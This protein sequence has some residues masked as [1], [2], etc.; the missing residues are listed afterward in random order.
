VVTNLKVVDFNE[1][2]MGIVDPIII[3]DLSAD[4]GEDKLNINKLLMTVYDN[5]D[6]LSSL[7]SCMC[8]HLHHGY[9]LNVICPLCKS[10]VVRPSEADIELKI[11]IRVPDGITGFI[12]PLVWV[13][14]TKLLSPSGYNLMEWLTNPRSRPA[15]KMSVDTS[16]IINTLEGM[17]WPR[18]INEFINNFDRLMEVIPTLKL[19]RKWGMYVEHFIRNRAVLFPRMLP[20][21]TK[22]LL[23]L[24]NTHLGSYADLSMSAAIDAVRSIITI[25]EYDLDPSLPAPPVVVSKTVS[26][27]KNLS[28][29]YMDT[30]KSYFF[31]K[32]GWLRGQVFSSRTHFCA[33]GVITS[34]TAEHNYEE[35]HIP[36]AQG[37][38]L[39]KYHIIP[40]LIA[41][42]Y[43]YKS[44]FDLIEGS[45][46]VYVRDLDETMQSLIN[47]ASELKLDGENI[48]GIPCISQRNPSLKRGSAQCLFIS[49]VKTDLNDPTFSISVLIVTAQNADFDGDEENFTLILDDD[50]RYRL[51]MLRAHYGMYDLLNIG[52]MS[53][54]AQ[55]P[56]VTASM[57]GRW[58]NE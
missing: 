34:I 1:L 45:G 47:D 50:M 25:S 44:A 27:I 16:S 36:W 46:N 12:S 6:V 22:A 55:L 2:Y 43:S 21:P 18:G 38:E 5:T 57:L 41:K 31:S 4:I 48:P 52:S 56:D 42:G 11:W 40:K 13:Q 49:R 9:K 35:I 53:N 33:R 54:V 23:V 10:P 26:V 37:L 8:G 28:G 15:S 7:P 39:L 20:V 51:S 58:L 30:M 17:N 32:K 24:E 3:N 14:M 29:Y 19:K